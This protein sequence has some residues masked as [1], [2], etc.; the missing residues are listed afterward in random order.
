MKQKF[1]LYQASLCQA[2]SRG[3]IGI[4]TII[5]TCNLSVFTTV[6]D[7]V[8]LTALK[9]FAEF[10]LIFLQIL[11]FFRALGQAGPGGSPPSPTRPA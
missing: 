5:E 9:K 11:Q 4:D 10:L 8:C 7:R 6:P 2:R 1:L 3:T